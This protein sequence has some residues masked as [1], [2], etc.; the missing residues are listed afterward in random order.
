MASE[1]TSQT[2]ELFDYLK[3]HDGITQLEALRELGIMRL[4][5]R[6]SD[7]KNRNVSVKTEMVT[8]TARNGRK[9]SVARYS[10]SRPEQ[11]T[12]D[13]LLKGEL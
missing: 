12:F 13:D 11:V 4:A 7:L 3:R 5:S 6:I 10:L 1:F 2:D 8:V 9:A